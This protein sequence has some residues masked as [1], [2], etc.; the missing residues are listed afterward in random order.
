[1]ERPPPQEPL[2]QQ[3]QQHDHLQQPSLIQALSEVPTHQQP[4]QDQLQQQQQPQQ[5]QPQQQ[6]LQQQPQ[7]QQQQSLY[8]MPTAL[9][10]PPVPWNAGSPKAAA[11]TQPLHLMAMPTATAATTAAAGLPPLSA[12]S[13]SPLQPPSLLHYPRPTPPYTAFPTA[14]AGA[15]QPPLYAGT[16]HQQQLHQQQ[17]SQQ[18]QQQQVTSVYG[19]SVVAS[20]LRQGRGTSF[21]ASEALPLGPP[22]LSSTCNSSSSSSSSSGRMTVEE[23]KRELQKRGIECPDS[24][25][26]DPQPE[27][28]QGLLSVALELVLGATIQRMRHEE[29]TGDVKIT[30]PDR[31][32]HQE[33]PKTSLI[34]S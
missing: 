18:Q 21:F 27:E 1:M 6:Q 25:W 24:L 16:L 15:L 29:I 26:K 3:Q 17:L 10:P 19:N 34:A 2:Q 20:P 13:I 22:G 31:S 11:V 5:Q 12:S 33:L 23:V 9:P 32:P 7:Q 14:G 4:Q 28:V 30:Q 8:P